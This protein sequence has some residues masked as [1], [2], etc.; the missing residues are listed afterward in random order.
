MGRRLGGE[1]GD[2]FKDS[3]IGWAGQMPF[4]GDQGGAL[5]GLWDPQT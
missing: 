2:H 4:A 5:P 1:D 3:A